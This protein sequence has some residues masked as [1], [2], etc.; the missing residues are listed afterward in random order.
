MARAKLIL[1]LTSI[2]IFLMA[3]GLGRAQTCTSDADC[4]KGLS[5]QADP[6]ATP[7][8][9]ICYAGDAS[10]ACAP[11]DNPPPVPTSSCRSAAC[12]TSADCGP[13][14]VC[15]SRTTTTCTGG[16]P[17]AVKCDPTT[18]ACDPGVVPDP[19][20][21]SCTDTVTS[22]CIYKYELPCN[23]DADCG[24]GFTCQP[25]VY[26]MCSGSS[27]T[28]SS[29]SG[30]AS[31]GTGGATGGAPVPAEVDAGA[32]AP[33]PVPVDAGMTVSSYPGH[34]QAKPVSCTVDTDCQSTWT[35]ALVTTGTAVSGGTATAPAAPSA[36][37][38]ST[39]VSVPETGIAV[40]PPETTTTGTC[41][42]PSS[43]GT[44]V[45][46]GG[47]LG[48]DTAKNATVDAGAATGST[49]PPAPTTNGGST[50]EP[51]AA[52]NSGGGGCSLG[53]SGVASEPA[54]LLGLL[55]VLGLMLARRRRS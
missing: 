8:V 37:D 5:C 45:N 21:V 6:I 39:V 16:T 31:A 36:P 9:A 18:T 14:M 34:C 55:G 49:M 46:Q 47:T 25:T 54:L 13:T 28:A 15:N 23:V 40:P 38:A 7:A 24:D 4:A 35:C 53:P 33:V 51:T 2:A 42:P 19:L 41:Q 44:F 48:T 43:S 26:G 29:G 30:S 17:V 12:L 50:T 32:A 11:V 1:G 20:P 52:T 22:R 3:P 10:G 27:G